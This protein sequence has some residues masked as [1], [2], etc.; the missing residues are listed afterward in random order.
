MCSVTGTKPPVH[1]PRETAVTPATQQEKEEEK[2]TDREEWK[3]RQMKRNRN[4]NTLKEA[5]R[6]EWGSQ[7]EGLLSVWR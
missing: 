2:E 5:Q 1:L 6:E 3:E 7:S 4:R